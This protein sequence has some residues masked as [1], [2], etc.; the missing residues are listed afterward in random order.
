MWG[1]VYIRNR[2]E[3]L[4]I[5]NE[6]LTIISVLDQTQRVYSDEKLPLLSNCY[7]DPFIIIFL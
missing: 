2:M 3:F 6:L 4:A 7:L 5:N 1:S